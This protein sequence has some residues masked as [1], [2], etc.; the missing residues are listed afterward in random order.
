MIKKYLQSLS[1]RITMVTLVSCLFLGAGLEVTAIYLVK[2]QYESQESDQAQITVSALWTTLNLVGSQ[3]LGGV[4]EFRLEGNKLYAG[5]VL[6]NGNQQIL[7]VAHDIVKNIGAVQSILVGDEQV[8]TT[9]ADPQGNPMIGSRFDRDSP[10]Y[11][12]VYTDQQPYRGYI[13]LFEGHNNY[14]AAFDPIKNKEGEVIGAVA[15]S[16]PVAPFIKRAHQL[17]I[18]L[19]LFIVGITSICLMFCAVV[20]N[21]L[22]SKPVN[23]I[24]DSL[25]AVARG[26]IDRPIPH[27][28]RL[29][30]LGKMA[31]ACDVFRNSVITTQRLNE[32]QKKFQEQIQKNRDETLQSISHRLESQVGESIDV[33]SAAASGVEN[34]AKSMSGAAQLTLKEARFVI[35]QATKTADAIEGLAKST[36]Q[37][38]S[39]IQEIGRLVEHSSKIVGNAVEDTRRTNDIVGHLAVGAEKIGNVVS[40]IENI[41]G[42]TNLLALNATIEAARAGEAGRG[43]AVVASEVKAL[44]NQ[45]ARAT[46]DIATLIG[47]MQKTT[48]DAVTAIQSIAQV[49]G[50]VGNISASIATAVHEQ[51]ASTAEITNT[52]A[53]VS[54]STQ[55]L[56]SRM[57]EVVNAARTTDNEA[58]NLLKSAQSLSGQ[59]SNLVGNLDQFLADVRGS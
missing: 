48:T 13:S 58:G 33:I 16:I 15:T 11:I 44:A 43:F 38:S 21:Y 31:R 39:S 54:T 46:Q 35:N 6:L 8:A 42:Q 7:N 1:V 29:D 22:V 17:E 9:L 27:L 10:A 25:E 3:S 34:S 59:T 45:T 37:I 30:V 4:A 2:Q 28:K 5:S 53:T 52:A 40:L 23:E 18:W 32:E 36:S 55:N 41:A 24:S 49:V 57:V 56:Q 47:D 51:G 14:Y 19:T 50:D 20:V 12:S 26:Q